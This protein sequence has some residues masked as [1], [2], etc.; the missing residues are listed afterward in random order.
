MNVR[1]FI[2][3]LRTRGVHRLA[4]IYC[5][6]AWALLQVADLFFPML[7]LPDESVTMVL[8]FAAAGFPFALMLSWWFDL[9]PEGVVSA[10]KAAEKGSTPPPGRFSVPHIV[11]LG[12]IMALILSVGNLYIERL[13]DGEA[14]AEGPG[15]AGR[16][17]EGRPSIAVMPFLDMSNNEEMGYLGDG[18]AEDILNLLARLNELNVAARTSSFLFRGKGLGVREI[19]E[20]LGVGHILE[21]SVRREGER[22]RVTARLVET[23]SG[24]QVW[25]N[26]YDR[27]LDAILDLQEEI[28]RKVVGSLK[29]A[30]S[31]R[32][33]NLLSRQRNVSPDAY[34]F[35]LRGRDYLRRPFD[36]SNIDAAISFFRRA[37]D[38][39]PEFVEAWAGLCDSLL[40]RYQD[41]RS[42]SAFR[43]GEDACRKA[44]ALDDEAI[45]VYVALGNLYRISGEYARSLEQ[46]DRALALNPSAVDA[47]LGRGKT[48]GELGDSDKVEQDLLVAI[49]LQPGFWRALAELGVWYHRSG[50]YQRAISYFQQVAELNP[51]SESAMNNLGSAFFL[52]GEF[53][54]A[55]EAWERSLALTPS[56]YT[57]SNLGGSL[58]FQER[59]EQA[60]DRYQQAVRLSPEDFKFWGYLAEAL[61]FVEGEEERARAALKQAITLGQS[62]LEINARDDRA[63]ARMATF[64]ARMGESRQA[65]TML[66]QTSDSNG[67]DVYT[68]YYRAMAYATLDET[69]AALEAL[70]RAVAMGYPSQLVLKDRNFAALRESPQFAAWAAKSGSV[71]RDPFTHPS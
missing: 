67:T 29:V 41:A 51:D 38:I 18:L 5:A 58:F 35:Y 19:A 62:H 30:L 44:L 68:F 10:S 43:R 42:A 17:L 70:E 14:A 56:A 2:A 4:A 33:S 36:D 63:R 7:G 24:F 32:S 46:F 57:L 25:S 49:E 48:F 53:A 16:N 13:G 52:A 59:F 64:Y 47:Y 8:L 20:Q 37:L 55:Q 9:T 34:E 71:G 11:E 45:A 31:P 65:R 54:L 6:S 39:N 15:F 61:Y 60:A 3:E 69:D 50:D 23:G 28:A 21:G 40:G 1:G 22:V 66:E 26:T 12:L 27:D